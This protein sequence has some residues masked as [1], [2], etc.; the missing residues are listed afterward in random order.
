MWFPGIRWAGRMAASCLCAAFRTAGVA[1]PKIHIIAQTQA[2][3]IC[4]SSLAA[5]I[6]RFGWTVFFKSVRLY[7]AWRK[8]QPLLL[9]SMQKELPGWE[10]FDIQ[11][12]ELVGFIYRQRAQQT[13]RRGAQTEGG[14]HSLHNGIPVSIGSQDGD[15]LPFFS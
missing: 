2:S 6:F 10:L 13:L 9:I 8:L 3:P 12:L 15:D 11:I 14:V 1:P 7:F 5:S 4:F